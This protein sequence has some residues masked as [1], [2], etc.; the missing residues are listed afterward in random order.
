MNVFRKLPYRSVFNKFICVLQAEIKHVKTGTEGTI[1][2]EDTAPASKKLKL[3]TNGVQA[4]E[5]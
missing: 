4:V 1:E 5:E 3:E 2:E